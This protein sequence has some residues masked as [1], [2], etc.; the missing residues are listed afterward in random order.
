MR[1][2]WVLAALLCTGIAA[3]LDIDA[4]TLFT[5]GNNVTYI[6]PT[7]FSC[8]NL[9]V[10]SLCLNI[11]G[12]PYDGSH[13]L[14]HTSPVNVL[15]NTSYI[16]VNLY[17]QQTLGAVTENV[18][19]GLIGTNTTEAHTT[20]GT[21]SFWNIT[22]GEYEI[23]T[24]AADYYPNNHYFTLS[25]VQPSEINMYLLNQSE[26]NR[27]IHT[28]YDQ[29]SDKAEGITIRL[30]RWYSS[31]KG[32]NTVQMA[33]TNFEGQAALYVELYDTYYK[34]Q[35]SR[36]NTT[37]K[38]TNT[39]YWF[40]TETEDTLNLGEDAFYSWRNFDDGYHK[41]DFINST[42][43]IYARYMFSVT[44][45]LLETGCLKVQRYT[46]QNIYDICNNCTTSSTAVL[47]C[48][49]NSTDSGEFKAVGWIETTTENSAY[50]TA[51]EWWRK[52]VNTQIPKTEGM[53]I[54]TIIVATFAMF[55]MASL[56]GS[57]V[58]TGVAL[59]FVSVTGFVVG[60]GIKAITVILLT[61]GLVSFLIWRA[62][63]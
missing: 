8:D 9:S 53:F 10:G 39:T 16:R 34:L 61:G 47:T 31:L 6:A 42:G 7:S 37:Y 36:A 51:I 13:C 59:V 60:I 52:T 11:S 2:V 19:I 28:L 55:G 17:D 44:S 4:G 40:E 54:A 48:K 57:L 41:I 58:L 38:I 25:T 29:D 3:A 21:H 56:T 46:I 30:L 32:Y 50:T 22:V 5:P 62:G 15:L 33:Q 26:G 14:S 49:I 23:K 45:G 12:G 35:Y 20:T 27:V 43:T 18:S 24:T 63:R 1:I